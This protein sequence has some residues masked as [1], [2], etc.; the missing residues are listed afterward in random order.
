VRVLKWHIIFFILCLFPGTGRFKLFASDSLAK[1]RIITQ[2]DEAAEARIWMIHEAKKE[3][4]ISYY[5]IEEDG[6]GLLI[7]EELIEAKIQLP[8]LT[9]LILVD[10]SANGLSE[11]TMYY[12]QQAGI[13]IREY[14]PLPKL[15][16]PVSHISI[17]GF[18]RAFKN[19]NARMHDKL[20]ITDRQFLLTGGRNIKNSYYGID[21][22]NFRDSD[23]FVHSPEAAQTAALYFHDIWES[24]NVQGLCPAID[25]SKREGYQRKVNQFSTIKNFKSSHPRYRSLLSRVHQFPDRWLPVDRVDFLHGFC[26]KRVE[27]YPGILHDTL[28]DLLYSAKSEILIETP[29]LL[30]TDDVFELLRAKTRAGVR[31]TIVTNSYC[32]TDIVAV[33]GAYDKIKSDL[34]AMGIHLYEFCGEEHLHSKTFII[35]EE[36]AMVGSYNMDPRSACINTEVILSFQGK[37]AVEKLRNLVDETL[38]LSVEVKLENGKSTETCTDCDRSF[39]ESFQY[40]LFRLLSNFRVVYNLM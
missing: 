3:I 38:L 11:E 5:I 19:L 18:V 14:N 23:I 33:S 29:Y 36:L 30:C 26:S 24:A 15:F 2:P 10:G 6:F 7:L 21:D 13:R 40:L 25:Y 31:I 20:F 17:S 8:E 34:L 12:I 35:D 9:I 39:W 28:L 27:I 22:I 16:V 32:S 1:V 37:K 4:L